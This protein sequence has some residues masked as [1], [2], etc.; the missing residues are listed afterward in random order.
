MNH[1]RPYNSRSSLCDN[2]KILF[3]ALLERK[4][5]HDVGVADVLVVGGE[6]SIVAERVP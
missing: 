5:N 2:S 3:S 1:L 4:T 6:L